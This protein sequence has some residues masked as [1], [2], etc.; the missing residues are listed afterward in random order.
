MHLN[1]V[2]ITHLIV[3]SLL[4]IELDLMRTVCFNILF[5]FRCTCDEGYTGQNCESEYFPC[6]PSP[7]MNGGTCHQRDKHSYT[8]E[9]PF[10]KYI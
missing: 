9:C 1:I 10:G 6:S 2:N 7:C 4:K 8:C 3:I 5:R